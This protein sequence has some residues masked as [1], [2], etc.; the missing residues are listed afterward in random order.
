MEDNK[1]DEDVQK[2]LE[3]LY[4]NLDNSTAYSSEKQI[5][6]KIQQDKKHDI[7][8]QMLKDWLASQNTYTSYKP[9]NK[10]FKRR[11]TVV[12]KKN[13]IWQA[14]CAYMNK[15][16]KKNEQFKYFLLTIDLLE[17]NNIDFYRS[18]NEVKCACA[19]RAIKTIKGKLFKYMHKNNTERWIDVLEKITNIYNKSIHSS[20]NTTPIKAMKMKNHVLYFNQYFPDK[21]VKKSNLIY[22]FNINDHVKISSLNPTFSREYDTRWSEEVFVITDRWRSDDLPQYKIKSLVGNESIL[23]TFYQKE[24]QLVLLRNNDEFVIEKILK[25][26]IKNKKEQV[27]VSWL[28]Y[29]SSYNSWIDSDNVKKL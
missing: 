14:D 29:D 23:G 5:Y 21:G 22:K 4:Y 6:S 18:L 20:I 10:K 19:E 24:L 13:Q 11:K 8:R 3:D 7:S 28:G 17:K 27:L 2:Y 16:W 12:I 1:L 15:L 9:A 25:K 26:R